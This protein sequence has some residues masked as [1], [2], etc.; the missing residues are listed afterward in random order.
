MPAPGTRSRRGL[1]A[2][3]RAALDVAGWTTGTVFGAVSRARGSKSLHPEG[4]V[5]EAVVQITGTGAAPQGARLLRE[6]AEHRA[7]VRFSRSFGLPDRLPDL[8][9][10]SLRLVDVHGP[11]R[12]QDF[13][14]VTSV[15]APVLHHVF[16]PAG[17]P[18]QRP[19][20]SSL[21]YT[22]G[23]ERFL[24]GAV[25]RGDMR[26]TLAVAPI[27]GRFEPVGEIRVGERLPQEL[28][29]LRFDPWNTGGGLELEGVFNRLRDYAYPLSQ[30]GWAQ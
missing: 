21:P 9:G 4:V 5:H 3:A 12:H 16:V 18:E 29:G 27:M 20:S 15:D 10:M 8:L 7:L 24:V 23:N 6:P 13:L 1:P 11:G 22:A 28:D 14:M 30:R 25:P 2:P 17:D 19:Y 26:F